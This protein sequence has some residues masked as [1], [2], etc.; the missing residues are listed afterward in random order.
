[1]ALILS[2][3]FQYVSSCYFSQVDPALNSNPIENW[4]SL[5]NKHNIL[6]IHELYHD[7]PK[8][9]RIRHIIPSHTHIP[10]DESALNPLPYKD[11]VS[12]PKYLSLLMSLLRQTSDPFDF[13]EIIMTI[14]PDFFD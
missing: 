1:M 13:Q 3:I 14:I 7:N 5:V 2:N 10:S 6:S 9:R 8:N 12:D 4:H 11:A